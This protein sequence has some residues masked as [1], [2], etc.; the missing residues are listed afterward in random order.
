MIIFAMKLMPRMDNL[1]LQDDLLME[2]KAERDMVNEQLDLLD[3]LAVLLRKPIATRI[4]H[5]GIILF[6]EIMAWLCAL[7]MIAF[8]VLRDKIYPFHILARIRSK[9]SDYGFTNTDVQQLYWSFTVF[10]V[11]IAVLFV[12]VARILA[13][14]RQKNTIIQMAAARIKTIVGQDLKRKA[15][16]ST[17]EQRHFDILQPLANDDVVVTTTAKSVSQITL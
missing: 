10:A 9:G 13:K 8:C 12:V 11:F 7:A 1:R 3:P 14:L 17:I 4:L 2:F 5:K 15:V 6:F 16:I